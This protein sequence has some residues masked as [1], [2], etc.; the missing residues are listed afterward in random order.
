ME[1]KIKMFQT[2]ETWLLTYA[3]VVVMGIGGMFLNV[4]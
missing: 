2:E 4:V 3:A 1:K